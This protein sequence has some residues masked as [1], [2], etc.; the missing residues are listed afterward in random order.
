MVTLPISADSQAIALICSTLALKGN[1]SLKALGPGEWHALSQAVH[2]AGMRPGELIGLGAG[3][4][5]E[6]LGL[7]PGLAERLALLLSRGGQLALEV[8]RLSSQGIWV[9]TRA[10][11]SYPTLLRRRLGQQAPPLLFGAGPQAGLENEAIAVVGSRDVDEEG[12]EFAAS[13]GATCAAQGLAVISGAARG[14]DAAA[15]GGA[16][17]RGGAVIGITVDPLERLVRRRDLR[18]AIAE[19][20]LSLATPFHPAARWHVG[21]AMR[22]NRLVYALSQAA[23]V[24]AS[25]SGKGGTRSGATENLKAGWVPLHVRDDGSP[26]NH[27]LIVAG[28][29]PLAAENPLSAQLQLR[30]L[31]GAPRLSLL[32]EEVPADSPGSVGATDSGEGDVFETVW[33]LLARQLQEPR[34][35]REIAEALDLQPT[36]ARAWLK[37]AAEQDLVAVETRP[38]RY[39]LRESAPGQMRMLDS[40]R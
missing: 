17:D 23:V 38:K 22:R 19:E 39:V 7:E 28:G 18:V 31:I 9:L 16:L 15:M 1:R 12:L 10:D 5:H 25:S 13:L 36:Q 4:L 29:M 30:E 8:E 33:P 11:D 21:N 27:Q 40:H 32:E 35:E 2:T 6:K 34:S 3:E 24:V 26:G 20:Q 14:V 37:R